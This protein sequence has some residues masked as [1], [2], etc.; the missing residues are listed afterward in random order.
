[1]GSLVS[2]VIPT[3]FRNKRLRETL[4]SVASQTHEPI[5]VIVVDDSGEGH[6]E[7]VVCEFEEHDLS[8]QYLAHDRNEGA[9]AA[10]DTGLQH[11][12]GDFVQ[13][14]D[15]DD[16]LKPEKIERQ[17]EF[18]HSH[19]EVGVVYC[20]F[21]YD[22]EVDGLL[23]SHEEV[24]VVY[25]GF[26]YDFEVDSPPE[27][28][29]R[30]DVLEDCLRFYDNP[31]TTSTMLI[32]V[33]EIEKIRP[34]YR[35]SSGSDDIRM[36][37]K[38]AKHTQFDYISN[39]LVIRKKDSDSRGTSWG[40]IEGRREI[41]EDFSE[42]Y[43]EYPKEV[44]HDALAEIYQLQ[45]RRYLDERIWSPNAIYS[46]GQAMRYSPEKSLLHIGEFLSS[47]AGRPGRK[48]AIQVQDTL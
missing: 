46:F 40:G 13:F 6:A 11:I 3:Y 17:V 30:G 21:E 26:E 9:H 20:G 44:Y 8:I 22:S 16:R 47:L 15:D 32:D 45:G 2:V 42:L 7:Q 23:H 25:C 41:L 19:E 27:P 10:R 33:E 29:T 36:S 28:T 18:L 1:M 48:L 35:N 14:L 37:I 4:Q 34:L 12:T 24:G 39:R 31:L 43:E 5:E 38:L